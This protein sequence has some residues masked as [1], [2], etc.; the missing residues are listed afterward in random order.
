MVAQRRVEEAEDFGQQVGVSPELQSEAVRGV[1]DEVEADGTP[2][3]V[4]AATR[5]VD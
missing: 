1:W 2:A 4:K 5:R 3:A